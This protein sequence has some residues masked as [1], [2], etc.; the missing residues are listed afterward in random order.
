MGLRNILLCPLMRSM[1]HAGMTRGAISFHNG[2]LILLR[3]TKRGHFLPLRAP[4]SSRL[5]AAGLVVVLAI[6]LCQDAAIAANHP[7][8]S[9]PH[10]YV[11][12]SNSSDYAATLAI[13]A[14]VGFQVSQCSIGEL[15]PGAGTKSILIV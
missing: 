5:V 14:S 4:I 10:V 1:L 11:I 15:P 2:H 8:L 6:L 12:N 13:F 3:C 9:I 7:K